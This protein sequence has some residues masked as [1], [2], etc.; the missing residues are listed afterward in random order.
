MLISQDDGMDDCDLS[1][2]ERKYIV[3]QCNKMGERILGDLPFITTL[4]DSVDA[5]TKKYYEQN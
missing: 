5:V 2:K 4:N 1:E 3:E